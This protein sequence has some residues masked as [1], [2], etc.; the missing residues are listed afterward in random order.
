MLIDARR[1]ATLRPSANC[2]QGR[3]EIVGRVSHDADGNTTAAEH[4]GGATRRALGTLNGSRG[5]AQIARTERF[6]G[7]A[8][9]TQTRSTLW[10]TSPVIGIV[11]ANR[12][13]TG[14]L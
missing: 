6:F 14:H 11:V 5:P 1:L 7:N 9:R 8:V 2:K 4:A 12:T 13:R 10:C 3:T